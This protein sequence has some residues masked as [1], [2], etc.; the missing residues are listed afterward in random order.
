MFIT[1]N[2]ELENLWLEGK[3]KNKNTDAILIKIN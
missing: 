3:I 2:N 1:S